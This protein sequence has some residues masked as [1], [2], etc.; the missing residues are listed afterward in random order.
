SDELSRINELLQ[1]LVSTAPGGVE[2]GTEAVGE[3]RERVAVAIRRR[4]ART[5]KSARRQKGEALDLLAADSR[6]L[7]EMESAL[8][9]LSPN[10]RG[11]RLELLTPLGESY[12]RDF[13]NGAQ[14]TKLEQ[15]VRGLTTVVE[16]LRREGSSPELAMQANLKILEERVT[17]HC[18][19]L[20]KPAQ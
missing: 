8:M 5:F 9:E 6:R 14:F 2:T 17:Q 16:A 15:L 18:T 1:Q 11:L 13:L 7:K 10:Q 12:L 4:A 20:A 3:A 19:A